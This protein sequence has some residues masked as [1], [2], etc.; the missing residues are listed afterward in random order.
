MQSPIANWTP[1]FVGWIKSLICLSLEAAF[2]S[3]RG[4]FY[5]GK[6]GIPNGGTLSVELANMAVKYV[7]RDLFNRNEFYSRNIIM[8]VRFVDDG[9]GIVDASETQFVD[10]FNNINNQ[11]QARFNLSFTYT[12]NPI[13][14]WTI[15]LDIKFKYLQRTLCTDINIKETDAVT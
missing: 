12:L 7:L 4:V 9:A 11:S 10:W 13:T 14:E 6:S 2:V 1:E 3:F 8:F 15:F 5:K